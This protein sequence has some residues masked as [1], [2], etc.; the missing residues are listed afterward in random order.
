[1]KI[2]FLNNLS[3]PRIGGGGEFILWEQM[4]ALRDCGH[5]CVLLATSDEP[6]LK[7]T[8]KEGITIWLAGIKNIYWPFHK[9][10]PSAPLRL[11]WHAIDIYNPLMQSFLRKVV[12]YEKPDI[13]SIHALQ[14]WS[15]ASWKMLSHLGVPSVQILHGYESICVNSSMYNKGHNCVG[16]CLHCHAFR[17]PHRKLSQHLQAVVG[18]SNYILKQHVSLGYFNNVPIQTV[19]HNARSPQS[20]GIDHSQTSH[21][22]I[23]FG[24]IGRLHPTK[25]VSLL[26]DAFSKPNLGNI[27]LWIAG[28]GKLQY[29]EKLRAKAH[30]TGIHF[31][32]QVTPQEFY[33]QVDVVIVPSLWNDN[34]PGVIFEALA[35][36]KPV[37]ASRRGGIPEMIQDGE[38]GLLFEPSVPDELES[39]IKTMCDERLRARMAAQA[40]KSSLPFIDIVHWTKTYESLYQKVIES[41]KCDK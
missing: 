37:I 18:V 10:R 1:M 19:I 9:K 25:G 15:S 39:A 28:S 12:H 31:M 17:L 23:R 6:G 21:N 20:L 11:I 30:D 16:Q 33:P 4:R 13:A 32:G 14:G 27:E 7:K 29:E 38:N 34:L 3:D 8:E 26:I 5:E 24:Y 36:G 35:F 22:G 40:L 41:Y 2:L